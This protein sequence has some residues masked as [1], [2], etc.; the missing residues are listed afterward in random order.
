MDLH[1]DVRITEACSQTNSVIDSADSALS[2][3]Q[4]RLP[5]TKRSHR[6]RNGY[7]SVLGVRSGLVMDMHASRPVIL[8]VED[9]PIVSGLLRHSLTRRGFDVE[10][11]SDGQQ[12]SALID[13]LA[14]PRLV[15]LDLLLPHTDGIELTSLI[16]GK[17]DWNGVPI[18]MLTAKAQESWM[19]RAHEAGVDD[20]IVKPFR[21]DEFVERVRR[22]VDSTVAA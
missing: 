9:D 22:L 15:V 19:E 2:P 6:R 16:R 5:L 17:P 21:P 4:K 20:Y 1:V 14:P 8:V 13:T 7:C 11:A 18:M 12:A 3:R 10:L